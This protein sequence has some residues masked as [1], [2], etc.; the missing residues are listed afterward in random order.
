MEVPGLFGNDMVTIHCTQIVPK[1]GLVIHSLTAD[2]T[3]L[4]LGKKTDF[5]VNKNGVPVSEESF[6]IKVG[7]SIAVGPVAITL[8]VAT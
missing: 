3:G 8:E 5:D 1:G 6:E 2:G 4:S 7:E